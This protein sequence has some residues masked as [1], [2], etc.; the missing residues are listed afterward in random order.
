M[1]VV[2]L[3]DCCLPAL[4]ISICTWIFKRVSIT[5]GLCLLSS[6]AAMNGV[7][8]VVS[9]YLFIVYFFADFLVLNTPWWIESKNQLASWNFSYQ[10]NWECAEYVLRSIGKQ[11]INSVRYCAIPGAEFY[12]KLYYLSLSCRI[13]VCIKFASNC[14]QNLYLLWQIISLNLLIILWFF[15]HFS[16][17]VQWWKIQ[18]FNAI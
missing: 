6:A 4:K 9:R 10:N 3:C 2:I 17:I 7:L 11:S 12:W 15:F 8:V 1:Q 14:N 13:R 16:R 5:V 18:W